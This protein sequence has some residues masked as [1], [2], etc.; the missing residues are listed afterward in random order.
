MMKRLFIYSLLSLFTLNPTIVWANAY[1]DDEEVIGY[2]QIVNELSETRSKVSTVT[3]SDPFANVVIHGGVGLVSSYVT[4]KPPSGKSHNGFLRGIEAKFGIDLFSRHW[5]AEG[6]VRSFSQAEI[7]DAKIALKEFDLKIVHKPFV[8]RYFQVLMGGGIAARYMD[9]VPG[10]KEGT[11][12]AKYTTPSSVLVLGG[13]VRMTDSLSLGLNLGYRSS[14]IDE[15]A[16]NSAFDI[17]LGL[18]AHF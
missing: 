3:D 4:A 1:G 18:D 6:A 2:D 8:G 9:Y 5:M 14:L 16:D 17:G 10:P 15:T 12:T 7:G 11:S 13:Q